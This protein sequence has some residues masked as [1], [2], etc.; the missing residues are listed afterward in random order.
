MSL[1]GCDK[2]M[3]GTIMAACRLD[4]P[5]LMVYGGTIKPGK[6][7]VGDPLDIVSA[8]QSYGTGKRD[9]I[10]PPSPPFFLAPFLSSRRPIV[11][12]HRVAAAAGRPQQQPCASE[13]DGGEEGGDRGRVR[14]P[15][16]PPPLPR[17]PAFLCTHAGEDGRARAHLHTG[18]AHK[19]PRTHKHSKIFDPSPNHP[20]PLFSFSQAPLPP[21]SSTTPPASTSSATRARARAPAAACTPPTRWRA[22][23]RRWG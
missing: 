22:R 8:F 17:P 16:M 12:T 21:A 18:R 11:L 9:E 1:P 10:T 4:R 7:R 15:T 23:S 6:D 20:P 5:A 3:P 13:G 14:P 19:V 2:N